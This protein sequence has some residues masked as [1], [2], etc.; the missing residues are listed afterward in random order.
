[1]TNIYL[2]YLNS[3]F[4]RRELPFIWCNHIKQIFR[5]WYPLEIT[6]R[7]KIQMHTVTVTFDLHAWP[8]CFRFYSKVG[9][10]THSLVVLSTKANWNIP[11]WP[12]SS[13]WNLKSTVT[14]DLLI[15]FHHTWWEKKV[16]VNY[17][18]TVVFNR[19]FWRNLRS[20]ILNIVKTSYWMSYWKP[21]C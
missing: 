20:A 19:M 16:S 5:E 7:K 13:F 2:W 9:F 6:P 15:G 8:I 18:S 12:K 14:F 3:L 17:Y 1:L 10:G 11:R 21:P 4:R